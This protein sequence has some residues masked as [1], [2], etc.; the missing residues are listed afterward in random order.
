MTVETG[1]KQRQLWTVGQLTIFLAYSTSRVTRFGFFLYRKKNSNEK[2][3]TSGRFFPQA[4]LGLDSLEFFDFVFYFSF[5]SP[6]S[7]EYLMQFFVVFFLI[8]Q[9]VIV[10]VIY[11]MCMCVNM[12]VNN[13]DK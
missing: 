12:C 11:S 2:M 13:Y 10:F 5:A 3:R 1:W 6:H 4:I 8:Q 9:S 7:E